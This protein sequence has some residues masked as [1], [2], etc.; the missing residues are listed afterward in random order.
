MEKQKSITTDTS[1]F[2]CVKSPAPGSRTPT[3]ED[4]LS[5]ERRENV[6]TCG[7][8]GHGQ[9]HLKSRHFITEQ[10]VTSG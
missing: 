7:I 4:Y 10:K 1:W 3:L 6:N 2:G 5:T 8:Y 9:S